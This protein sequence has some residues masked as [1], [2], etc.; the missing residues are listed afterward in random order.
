MD[1]KG[2]TVVIVTARD[3]EDTTYPL[4]HSLRNAFL[5]GRE[6]WVNP[7]NK[8]EMPLD[9]R[10]RKLLGGE[11][12][13]LLTAC[14]ADPAPRHVDYQ[15]RALGL[16][17]RD[18]DDV[19][20]IS[21]VHPPGHYEIAD[22][23]VTFFE[24]MVSPG[25]LDDNPLSG[26]L[27]HP[28]FK[29][30]VQRRKRNISFGCADKN[31]ALLVC[32]TRYLLVLDDCCLPGPGLVEAAYEVCEAGDVFLPTHRQWYLPTVERPYLEHADS[33][34]SEEGH[35]VMGIWGA[36]LQYFL[37]IN[38]WN[39][40]LDTQR[41]GLDA[42]LKIRMDRYLKMRERGYQYRPHTKVYEL[43]HTYPWADTDKTRK[44]EDFIPSGCLAPGPNLKE[45]HEEVQKG[46]PLEW[47]DKDS[48]KKALDQLDAAFDDILEDAIDDAIHEDDE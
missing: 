18:P 14:L 10:A 28:Q 27:I 19:I 37:A 2:I 5:D 33:N 41:G 38:G 11:F 40:D 39:T 21:R 35:Q 24:P 42:E 16:Q 15:I 4:W 26:L 23:E 13:A 46:W 30:L 31:T 29:D 20:V 43:Q 22:Q 32:G 9:A 25:E 3:D 47:G 36:P 8:V 34:T 7:E 1:D 12:G 45:L 48:M 6:F 44:W 17:T